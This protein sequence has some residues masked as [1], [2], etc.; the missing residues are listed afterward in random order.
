VLIC[1]FAALVNVRCISCVNCICSLAAVSSFKM[2][3]HCISL[4]VKHCAMNGACMHFCVV[5]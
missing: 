3:A 1:A 4:T 2:F 5:T